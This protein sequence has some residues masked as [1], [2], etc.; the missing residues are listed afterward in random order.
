[1]MLVSIHPG[2]TLEDVLAT[3][4]FA[5]LVPS[6]V[7]TTEPPEEY[8]LHLIREVIDPTKMYMG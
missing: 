1:M 8:Q 5:P 7:P 4:G 6:Q 3:M 2:N